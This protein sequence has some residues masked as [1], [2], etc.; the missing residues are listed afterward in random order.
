M[1]SLVNL[2]TVE[3]YLQLEQKCEIRHEYL[4]GQVFAMCG[5]SKEHNRISLNIASRVRSHL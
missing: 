3:E 2:F 5:G 4:G 1:Q